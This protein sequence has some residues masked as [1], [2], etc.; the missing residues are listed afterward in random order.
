[1]Q[2]YVCD[3]INH[4]NRNCSEKRNKLKDKNINNKIE[5]SKNFERTRE[6]KN[7]LK[8]SKSFKGKKREQVNRAINVNDQKDYDKN[9]NN[10]SRNN[11]KNET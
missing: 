5:D 10:T 6:L 8:D 2:C 7:R 4:I 3:K 1:M 9:V 11:E